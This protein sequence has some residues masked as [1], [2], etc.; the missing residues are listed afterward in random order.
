MCTVAFRI[1]P[2]DAK[3][4]RLDRS[5]EEETLLDESLSADVRTNSFG[6]IINGS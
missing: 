6:D 1:V 4:G 2:L 5:P 3:V